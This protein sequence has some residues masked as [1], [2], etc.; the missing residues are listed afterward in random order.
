MVPAS[1]E[2]VSEDMRWLASLKTRSTCEVPML[3][4]CAPASYF[5]EAQKA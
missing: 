4:M 5:V 3:H 2:K 1:E